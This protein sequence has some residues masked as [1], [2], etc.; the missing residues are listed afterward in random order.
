MRLDI[1][2]TRA[3]PND[4]PPQPRFTSRLSAAAGDR[5]RGALGVRHAGGGKADEQKAEE[6]V[7]CSGTSV[8]D[9]GP[10]S[11]HAHKRCLTCGHNGGGEGWLL[12]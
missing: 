2:T 9:M 8:C 1:S 5:R 10:P 3:S 12:C 7:V 4:Q 6:A 11:S